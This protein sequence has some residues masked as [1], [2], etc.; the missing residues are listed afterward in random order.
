MASTWP[1]PAERHASWRLKNTTK[2]E[3]LSNTHMC[4]KHVH[5]KPLLL[6]L[7]LLPQTVVQRMKMVRY[8]FFCCANTNC[9]NNKATRELP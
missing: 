4:L 5:A 3:G 8:M 7:P 1:P 9:Q 2:C 6:L